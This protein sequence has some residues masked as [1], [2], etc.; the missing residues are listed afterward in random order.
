M[1]FAER[2][3]KNVKDCDINFIGLLLTYFRFFRYRIRYNNRVNRSRSYIYVRY[4]YP[5]K[6]PFYLLGELV[7]SSDW[8]LRSCT[9]STPLPVWY[10]HHLRP[11]YP[12]SVHGVC[13]AKWAPRTSRCHRSPRWPRSAP[14]WCALG[15]AGWEWWSST[16]D[17]VYRSVPWWVGWAD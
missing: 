1:H 2:Y 5:N 15:D 8:P 9:F 11:P 10:C 17:M 16:G 7:S 6:S 12:S 14:A 3:R 13:S 4:I